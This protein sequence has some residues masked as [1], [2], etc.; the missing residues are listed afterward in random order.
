[1]A[2]RLTALQE[3]ARRYAVADFARSVAAWGGLVASRRLTSPEEMLG[4]WLRFADGSSSFVFR[5]TAVTEAGTSDPT[6]LVIQF[7]LAFLGSNRQLHA[8]F[9]RECVLHTPLFA[10]FPGF[11][12]K[13]WIDDVETGVYRGVYQWEGADLARH[14]AA[15]MVALLAPFSNAGTA[16]Y[17]VVE[18]L[19]R[20]E[21]LLRP[22]VAPT[23]AEGDWWRL[24]EPISPRHGGRR[25]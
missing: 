17:Q 2:S 18:G 9:R 20:D 19:R 23:H 24:A 11:R 25:L 21:F 3:R 12:S 15:R 10:G 6:L 1:M 8:A 13:L 7:R 22:D 5:E 16:R 14:Y 4:A